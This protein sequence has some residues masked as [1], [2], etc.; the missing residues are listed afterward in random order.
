MRDF[1]FS[2]AS[3]V[4]DSVTDL[5]QSD[6]NIEDS[7]TLHSGKVRGKLQLLSMGPVEGAFMM[8]EGTIMMVEG[9]MI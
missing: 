5:Q 1:N 2:A 3:P 7:N 4:A 8:V 9:T 6:E